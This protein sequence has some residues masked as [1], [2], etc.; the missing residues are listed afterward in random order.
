VLKSGT[1]VGQEGVLVDV[2]VTGTALDHILIWTTMVI[3]FGVSLWALV[4]V[5]IHWADFDAYVKRWKFALIA[6]TFS[7]CFLTA[8]VIHKHLPI[9]GYRYLLLTLASLYLVYV[10][11]ANRKHYEE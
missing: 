5:T 10:L 11:I 9:N 2:D 1:V 8:E 3:N 7:V 4:T 6:Y